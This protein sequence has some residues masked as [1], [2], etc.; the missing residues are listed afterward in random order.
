M[1]DKVEEEKLYD[2]YI[3]QVSNPFA[4]INV[5]FTDWLKELR[6]PEK[7]GLSEKQVNTAVEE[8]NKM[9]HNFKPHRGA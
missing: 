3:A 6:T 9:L 5:S 1:I 7:H 8:A 4:E 2:L